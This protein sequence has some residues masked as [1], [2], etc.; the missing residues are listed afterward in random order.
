MPPLLVQRPQP[1][2]SPWLSPGVG[3]ASG[4]RP[5]WNECWA[6]RVSHQG[7]A[8]A[9][10]HCPAGDL[11]TWWLPAPGLPFLECASPS[12]ADVP[13]PGRL[14]GTPARRLGPLSTSG[15]FPTSP[16]LGF[17]P[18]HAPWDPAVGPSWGGRVA[19]VA[20]SSVSQPG[21]WLQPVVVGGC[22][23]GPRGQRRAGEASGE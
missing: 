21:A 5:A 16:E 20:D 10:G 9:P 12:S 7:G 14:A 3:A 15:S 17:R 18:L 6:C 8:L 4:N 19:P 13:L 1:L 22:V 11:C 23:C 2:K